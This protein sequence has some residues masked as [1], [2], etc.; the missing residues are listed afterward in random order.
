MHRPDDWR[1][2]WFKSVS[3]YSRHNMFE[4]GA[5]AMLEALRKKGFQ[6]SEAQ[7]V[8]GFLE[9]VEGVK[10]FIPGEE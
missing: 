5:D 2:P 3:Y 10:V 6:A 1:N 9:I 8:K 4:A 7:E